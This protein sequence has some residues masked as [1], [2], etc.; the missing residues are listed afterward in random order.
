MQTGVFSI[1]ALV[2]FYPRGSPSGPHCCFSMLMEMLDAEV[3]AETAA[4]GEAAQLC[5]AG[6]RGCPAG[7]AALP[8]R[9]V[10]T[11]PDSRNNLESCFGPFREV[12]LSGTPKK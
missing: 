9:A 4:R 12:T 8:L 11:K 2:I 3:G 6:P 1:A 5:C 10:L 7:S